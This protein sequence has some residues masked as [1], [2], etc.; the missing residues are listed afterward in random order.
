MAGHLLR[1][2]GWLIADSWDAA[3]SAIR[4][5]HLTMN[6]PQGA[7]MEKVH[8]N[9][10]TPPTHFRVNKYT[11]GFQEFVNTY[12]IPRFKEVNPALF[13][14][15]TFPFLFGIMYGDV[16]HGSILLLGAAFLVI[17]EKNFNKR[18][19]EEMTYSIF[20]A[21]Y[22][23]LGMGICAV[24]CGLVY[25]DYFA[26]GLN[27][28]GSTYTFNKPAKDLVTGDTASLLPGLSYGEPQ[29]VYT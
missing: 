9:W 17:T 15:A 13:T 6:L 12:G 5:A 8:G 3:N 18:T 25:N 16:G 20:E 22:M 10:P 14:A 29:A 21:R 26:L 2:R 11:H 7:L 19:T 23:L 28:F 4:K 27:L 1:A 24:Y